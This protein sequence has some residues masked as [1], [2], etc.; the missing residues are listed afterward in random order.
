MHIRM[1]NVNANAHIGH[2]NIENETG[3]VQFY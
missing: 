2:D 3:G 1:I